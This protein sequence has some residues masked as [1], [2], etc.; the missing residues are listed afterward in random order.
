MYIESF[1]SRLGEDYNIPTKITKNL[2]IYTYMRTIIKYLTP[3]RT[4]N[5][6]LL[7]KFSAFPSKRILRHNGLSATTIAKPESNAQQ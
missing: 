7:N 5:L 1:N 3:Y 4:K 6:N 2:N